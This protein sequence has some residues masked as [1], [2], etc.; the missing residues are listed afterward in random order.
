MRLDLDMRIDVAQ[1]ISCGFDLATTQIFRAVNDL[2]L[3]VR[4]LDDVE[5]DDPDP[6]HARGRQVHSQR[7]PES[8]RTDH[9]HARGF[10]F[11]LPLHAYFRHDQVAAVTH[12]LFVRKLRQF[13]A[14][15]GLNYRASGD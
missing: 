12:D 14:H 1:T 9:Q 7:R 4:L 2:T 5:I 13:L 11:S 3:Q 15:F 6:A 10:Q 8:A